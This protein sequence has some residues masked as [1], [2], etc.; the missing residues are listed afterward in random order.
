MKNPF[1]YAAIEEAEKGIAAGAGGP[2]GAVIVRR[3]AVLARA[4]NEVLKTKDPTAHAE[5][6]AIR[7]ASA[8]ARSYDLSG[9]TIYSTCEPC[10]MCLGA[11]AWARIERVVYGCTALDAATIGFYDGEL[12]AMLRGRKMSRE[13]SRRAAGLSAANGSGSVALIERHAASVRILGRKECLALF[14]R[15]SQMPE[16]RLY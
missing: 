6:L 14:T 10:P 5:V 1:L 2:F 7:R 12:H 9:C 16:R 11:I 15:W 8:K 13:E 3:G 4:H